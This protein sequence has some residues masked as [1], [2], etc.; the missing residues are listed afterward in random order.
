MRANGRTT[1]CT[2]PTP[3][4]AAFSWSGPDGPA[5][6]GPRKPTRP[7]TTTL[8]PGKASSGRPNGSTRTPTTPTTG[9]GADSPPTVSTST[10]RTIRCTGP[11]T[12]K[13]PPCSGRRISGRACSSAGAGPDRGGLPSN[14]PWNQEQTPTTSVGGTTVPIPPKG[15]KVNSSSTMPCTMRRPD[16]P[17]NSARLLPSNGT[18]A[19]RLTKSNAPTD[20]RRRHPILDGAL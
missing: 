13:P 11:N 4:E 2:A 5:G 8:A 9:L 6:S 7:E 18:K 12:S 1:C 16:S 20:R 14:S 3:S 10:Y 17:R 19:A 15:H